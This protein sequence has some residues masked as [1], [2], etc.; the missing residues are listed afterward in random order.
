MNNAAAAQASLQTGLPSGALHAQSATPVSNPLQAWLDALADGSISG[1]SE[2]LLADPAL[3]TAVGPGG[4]AAIHLA[5]D[6]DSPA[7]IRLL[8]EHGASVMQRVG[9]TGRHALT[10]A[11]ERGAD[12]QV[13]RA[14]T[15]QLSQ[16]PAGVDMPDGQGQTALTLAVEA[17]NHVRVAHL[18]RLGASLWAADGR[19]E[20]PLRL[21]I[22]R[23]DP[24]LLAVLRDAAENN[25]K[26]QLEFLRTAANEGQGALFLSL[27]VAFPQPAHEGRS[28]TDWL[29]QVAVTAGCA[30]AV[31][32]VLAKLL[33]S[34]WSCS[35]RHPQLLAT[36]ARIHGRDIIELL[37]DHTAPAPEALRAG[38]AEAVQWLR[39][40]AMD[41]LV[42]RM[43]EPEIECGR[44]L[45]AAPN[46]AAVR[47]LLGRGAGG[48]AN[49]ARVF[50]ASRTMAARGDALSLEALLQSESGLLFD[51]GQL[52]AIEAAAR[53]AA[54]LAHEPR[55]FN[56]VFALLERLRG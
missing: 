33:S 48:S 30:I 26:A 15:Q 13:L 20:T 22:R 17:N 28:T 34:G 56:A 44:L 25:R 1:I 36:A 38:L 32:Q 35:D 40:E 4:K 47:M 3:A 6:K 49:A 18:A 54:A 41:V 45:A 12:E 8:R 53:H 42:A 43:D 16:S 46:D 37:L 39:G 24:A 50:E 2:L 9:G 55:E 31:E 52:G 7:L 23:G 27:W 19:G 14:L 21:A 5:V 29:L 10:W 51:A 11:V